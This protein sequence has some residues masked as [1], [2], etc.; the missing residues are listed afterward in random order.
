MKAFWSWF[1]AH[2][3]MDLVWRWYQS[4]SGKY[5]CTDQTNTQS[6]PNNSPTNDPD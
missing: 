2:Q 5:S 6:Y 4:R 3:K 1:V